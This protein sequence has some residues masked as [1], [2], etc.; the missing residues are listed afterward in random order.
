MSN[1]YLESKTFKNLLITLNLDWLKQTTAFSFS[2][3]IWL[4]AKVLYVTN[5]WI[6]TTNHKR[7]AVNYFL[8]VIFAGIVGSVLATKR[9]S[10]GRRATVVDFGVNLLFNAFWYDYKLKQMTLDEKIGQLFMVSAYSNK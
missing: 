9:L 1:W 5:N 3:F 6:Y 7:I 10:D 8:F 2:S 4:K